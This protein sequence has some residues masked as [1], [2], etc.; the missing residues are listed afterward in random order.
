MVHTWLG[1]SSN[2]G[3]ATRAGA[4]AQ[5]RA[6]VHEHVRVDQIVTAVATGALL[7]ALAAMP[8]DQLLGISGPACTIL[9]SV[10]TTAVWAGLRSQQP[11]DLNF[12]AAVL[13]TGAPDRRAPHREQ[14]EAS[15]RGVGE[16]RKGNHRRVQNVLKARAGS[17][18]AH[19]GG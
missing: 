16:A 17:I 8:Y 3:M 1:Q 9:R 4:E 11:H 12:S 13:Q 2:N 10:L 18:L 19:H 14:A 5:G 15:F 7:G 6:V